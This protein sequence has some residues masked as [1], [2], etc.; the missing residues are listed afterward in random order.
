MVNPAQY[1]ARYRHSLLHR[2]APFLCSLTSFSLAFL[3]SGGIGFF[4]RRPKIP[5]DTAVQVHPTL[6][7]HAGGGD[8]ADLEDPEIGLDLAPLA[9]LMVPIRSVPPKP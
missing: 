8:G 4:H 5:W 6:Q 3:S 1:S 7:A 9:A 2:S